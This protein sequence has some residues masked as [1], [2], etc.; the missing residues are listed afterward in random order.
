MERK[1]EMTNEN[2]VLLRKH[3][4]GIDCPYRREKMDG[5]LIRPKATWVSEGEENSKILL[6]S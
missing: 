2:L 1:E 3:I 6:Q 4:S 5:V